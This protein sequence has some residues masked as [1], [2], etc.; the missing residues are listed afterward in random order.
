ML[1]SLE[2]KADPQ[3]SGYLIDKIRR[4]SANT[5]HMFVPGLPPLTPSIDR[6]MSGR[7]PH[8]HVVSK[9]VEAGKL[10]VV[11]NYV[12]KYLIEDIYRRLGEHCTLTLSPDAYVALLPSHD[13]P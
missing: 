1:C 9:K 2:Q 12:R 7:V 10:S 13:V 6:S 8:Y 3:R 11:V 4:V 5:T